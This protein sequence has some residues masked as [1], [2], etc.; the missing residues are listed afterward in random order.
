MKLTGKVAIVTGGARGIGE[1]CAK[2][3]AAEGAGVAIND[4]HGGPDL[5]GVI[6][7]IEDNRGRA[8][9]L[10]GDI[11]V[12]GQVEAFTEKVISKFGRIDILVHNA[13]VIKHVGVMEATESDWDWMFS[14]NVNGLFYCTQAAARQMIKQGDG[15]RI[16]NVSSMTA[17]MGVGVAPYSATKGAVDAFTRACASELAPHG[18]RVNSVAPGHC[19]TP[20]NYEYNTPALLRAFSKRIALGRIARPED[21]AAAVVFFAVPESEYI[22]GESLLVDGGNVKVGY[23]PLEYEEEA[24]R[25][26]NGN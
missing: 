16:I 3:L 21:V 23:L 8:I 20:L 6:K 12:R 9:A 1:A 24:E 17:H 25:R 13:G 26:G 14:V 11:S 2:A 22:T 15:G 5:E 10:P 4:L 7:A 19:D 18:I